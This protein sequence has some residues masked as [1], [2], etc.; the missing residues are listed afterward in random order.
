VQWKRL[1]AAVRR[2]GRA[3]ANPSPHVQDACHDIRG[4]ALTALVSL[5]D[6]SDF[7]LWTR[8]DLGLIARLA[9]DQALI[10]CD[11]IADLDPAPTMHDQP[12]SGIPAVSL[13][14]RWHNAAYRIGERDI[15]VRV[16]CRYDGA[17]ACCRCEPALLERVI[18]NLINNAAHYS[19]DG[20]IEIT[21]EQP[22]NQAS[23]ARITI[24]NRL[25]AEQQAI[26]RQAFPNGPEALFNGGFTTEGNGLGMHIAARILADIHGFANIHECLAAR[27]I[28]V[29]LQHGQF[30]CW[31]DWPLA[32]VEIGVDAVMRMT[33]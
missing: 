13:Y 20:G 26:L 30:I 29:A 11:L 31:F 27:R 22:V 6:T 9:R 15:H 21:I 5:L 10:M 25:T 7:T 28:G 1:I 2:L 17:I 3:M 23:C 4:G 14:E 32:D 19:A 33:A 18:Y 12:Q 16:D 8:D 24:A